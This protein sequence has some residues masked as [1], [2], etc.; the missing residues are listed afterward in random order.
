MLLTE[1]NRADTAASVERLMGAKAETRFAFI[2]EGAEF[3][4]EAMLDV[5]PCDW[6][7]AAGLALRIAADFF[8][9][10]S[11]CRDCRWTAVPRRAKCLRYPR[12]QCRLLG[13]RQFAGAA[14]V[15][16]IRQAAAHSIVEQQQCVGSSRQ[17]CLGVSQIK[18]A[19]ANHVSD[20]KSL[21]AA[22]PSLFFA[23]PWNWGIEPRGG[24][25]EGDVPNQAQALNA[26]IERPDGGGMPATDRPYPN[27]R[28]ILCVFPRYEPSLGSFHFAYDITGSLRAFMPPQG[29]LVIAA[30]LPPGWQ[31]K[32]VDENI[33]PAGPED[34]RWADAV[35]V[36][37]M[38]VQ[39]K[40]IADIC[41]QAHAAGKP[42][43]L[44]G[45][46]V[47]ASPELYPQFDYIHVGE[48]GDA[49]TELFAILARDCSRPPAQ[50]RLETRER[51]PLDRFPIPAYELVSF[52]YYFIGSIQFSSGCP[53]VCE[54]CDIPG[55]YGRVPRLKRPRADHC[56][57]RQAA[58]LR[59]F[60]RGLFRRRQFH[61]QPPRGAR[62]AAASDRLAG[63]QFV[64]AQ[65]RVRI[66][67]QHREIRGLAGG[68]ARPPISSACSA[69]SRR[70]SPRRCA[71]CRRS[72]TC[73]VPILEAVER[74]NAYGIEVI[75]GIIVGLDTDSPDTA[76][77]IIEF[78]DR[79]QIPM[80][81][82]NLLQALPRTPLWDRLQRDNRITSDECLESNV[83]FKM[84]YDQTIAIWRACLKHAYDPGRLFKR[85]DTQVHRTYPNR[86]AAAAGARTD[87]V[88][89]HQARAFHVLQGVLEARGRGRLPAAFLGL[90]LAAAERGS[91][92]GDHRHRHHR[93]APDRLLAQGVRRRTQCVE[94]FEQVAVALPRC[95]RERAASA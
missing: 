86:Q 94:L 63:A 35:F 91:D 6:R 10:A 82:I 2:Q 76:S 53:F 22:L 58:G 61:R 45:P 8:G 28:R 59:A 87:H 54:F 5:Q 41:R 55:L 52:D 89:E 48:L 71:A 12:L 88:Q 26:V 20:K 37:G 64:S 17:T 66:D 47:S 65:I 85:Y 1:D 43:V 31:V 36:S 9:N 27:T 70:R 72:R 67:P 21:P 44:G 62:I 74:L 90:C 18:K 34:F 42:A 57:T 73:A 80:L 4:S 23:H 32:F 60:H 46:S 29:L 49:T 69:A 7:L 16:K 83:V 33:A 30:A 56:R 19:A 81:T 50:V 11:D 75:A 14:L 25:G 39:R 78:I 79:S 84:P 95:I 38:H 24:T 15:A 92:R 51:L 77:R 3:A 13:R 68:D 40:Q 93:Q